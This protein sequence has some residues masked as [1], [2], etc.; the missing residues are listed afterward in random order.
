MQGRRSTR[1]GFPNGRYPADRWTARTSNVDGD[2]DGDVRGIVRSYRYPMS[3][4]T[5]TSVEV[6]GPQDRASGKDT[7]GEDV[8]PPSLADPRESA[9]CVRADPRE[10]A[11]NYVDDRLSSVSCSS[12]VARRCCLSPLVQEV[13][14]ATSL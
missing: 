14:V 5:D 10:S 7:S 2:D 4:G 11:G 12:S 8:C 1:C 3:C 9:S 6:E 13:I